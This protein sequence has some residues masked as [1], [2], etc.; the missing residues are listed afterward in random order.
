[1]VDDKWPEF[2][3]VFNQFNPKKLELLSAENLEALAKDGRII[4][5]MQ[6]IVTVP[7]NAQWIN[8]IADE[9]GSF[10]KFIGQWPTSN[11]IELF[12]LLNKKGARLG[13][14]TGQRGLR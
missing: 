9:H 11:V 7:K 12:K 5:S 8:E 13:G 3:A 6:K 2:E 10:A 4:R 14:G 1:M